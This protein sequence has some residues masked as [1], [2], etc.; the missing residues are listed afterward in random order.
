MQKGQRKKEIPERAADGDP[1]VKD[2]RWND[3]E[4]KAFESLK[5]KLYFVIR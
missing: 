1:I 2:I 3:D 5:E 4:G